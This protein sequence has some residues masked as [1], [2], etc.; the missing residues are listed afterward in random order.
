MHRS[1]TLVALLLAVVLVAC[2]GPE[3]AA[4]ATCADYATQAD[5]Q[6]AADTRD[7]D[8]DGVFCVISRR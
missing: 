5:A 1:A 6:R 7:A 8:G 4:A 2:A 3:R